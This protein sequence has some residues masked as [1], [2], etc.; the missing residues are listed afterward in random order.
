VIA[1]RILRQRTKL[2]MKQLPLPF[3]FAVSLVALAWSNIAFCE[4]TNE[5]PAI[6]ITKQGIALYKAGKTQDAIAVFKQAANSDAKESAPWLWLGIVYGDIKDYEHSLDAY[7]AAIRLNPADIFPQVKKAV[8]LFKLDR[9]SEV[10]AAF[11]NAL[12]V[13]PKDKV[14]VVYGFMIQIYMDMGQYEKSRDDISAYKRLG[15]ND[16]LVQTYDLML[17]AL[18]RQISGINLPP[19]GWQPPGSYGVDLTM[20]ETAGPW[21]QQLCV[22]GALT[23]MLSVG[24]KPR[25]SVQERELFV[26]GGGSTTG[27]HFDNQR[28]KFAGSEQKPYEYAPG[29]KIWNATVIAVPQ[30]GVFV[31]DGAKL[32]KTQVV[33]GMRHEIDG[34]VKNWRF[35]FDSE[36]KKPV[37]SST[38]PTK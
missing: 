38:A 28:W 21:L 15:G 3:L 32:R 17:R 26:L 33:D 22:G 27:G 14:P 12:A 19:D 35:V 11:T 5:S 1:S 30:Y 13:A 25:P 7:N 10:D 37:P 18:D 34:I 4:Q 29:L 8:T 24:D 31:M 9:F 2:I 6:A 23:S 20:N 16:D 36:D